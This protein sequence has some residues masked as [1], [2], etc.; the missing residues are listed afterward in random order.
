MTQICRFKRYTISSGLQSMASSLTKGSILYM[1]FIL[2]I[3]LITMNLGDSFN[4]V[5]MARPFVS[6]VLRP[7]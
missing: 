3:G 2:Y 6:R 4:G 5:P 7:V 1:G